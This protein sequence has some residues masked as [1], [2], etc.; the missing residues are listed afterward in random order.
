MCQSMT[1]RAM[2][3]YASAKC[4]SIRKGRLLV[5]LLCSY[6]GPCGSSARACR[7]DWV[8]WSPPPRWRLEKGVR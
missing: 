3:V 8:N 4:G 2:W 1:E 6:D 5:G 7:G